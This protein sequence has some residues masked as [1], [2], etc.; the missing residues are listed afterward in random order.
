MGG[1]CLRIAHDC[2][3]IADIE[4]TQAFPVEFGPSPVFESFAV[5]RVAT[6]ATLVMS[7]GSRCQQAAHSQG[8]DT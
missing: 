4:I 5:R 6:M 2:A 7:V 8:A 3:L 1:L